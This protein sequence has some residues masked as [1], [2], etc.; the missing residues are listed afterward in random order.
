MDAAA[1]LR[2]LTP[3]R[4]QTL[5][6]ALALSFF[7]WLFVRPLRDGV[8]MWLPFAALAGVELHFFAS[9]LLERT[10]LRAA[11]GLVEGAQADG[12]DL[13]EDA[14][15]AFAALD[16]KARGDIGS[17]WRLGRD[18]LLVVDDALAATIDEAGPDL[19]WAPPDALDRPVA[20]GGGLRAPWVWESAGAAVL[21]AWLGVGAVRDAL[22]ALLVLAVTSLAAAGVVV[23]VVAE[24]GFPVRPRHSLVTGARRAAA[25]AALGVVVF[26]LVRPAGWEALP[27]AERA[28]A[29]QVFS[30][31]ASIIAGKQVTVEC[32]T[33]GAHT[34]VINDAAGA[35]LVGGRQAWLAPSICFR[36]HALEAH[37]RRD[38]VDATSW[39]IL[40]L[41]HESWHLR[42]SGNEG[43]TDCYGLQSGVALGRRLGLPAAEAARLMRFR[44]GASIAEFS[45]GRAQY[46]LPAGCRDGGRYDLDPVSTRFP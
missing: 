39:A 37:G 45:L 6:L 36:L 12:A 41:A 29:E 9:G 13:R 15:G 40:V 25:L 42:G 44:W 34:G 3:R 43:V 5:R 19:P 7:L 30:R 4:R 27:A 26:L 16:P 28:R 23:R 11:G 35:A 22:P 18:A 8:S 21:A 24:A 14:D 38:S 20:A 32:D 17:D 33:A 10:R 2:R 1:A 46:L 31:Q